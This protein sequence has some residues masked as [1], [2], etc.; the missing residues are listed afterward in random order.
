MTPFTAPWRSRLRPAACLLLFMA[1]GLDACTA[2]RARQFHHH[3]TSGDDH[4]LAR[5]TVACDEASTDCSEL[6]LIKGGACLRLARTGAAPA[7]H[8][9]CSADAL[10]R[11]IALRPSWPEPAARR[12]VQEQLCESLDHLLRWPS[13]ATQAEVG[14]RFRD[15]AQQLYQLAP[16]SVAAT[17][18]LAAARMREIEPLL[19]D[20]TEPDRIPVCH[21]L[22]RALS[23]VL[24]TMQSNGDATSPEWDRYADAYQRL[25]FELGRAIRTAQCR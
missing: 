3:A 20:I 19:P 17:Y 15:A 7:A 22:K 12:A 16:G 14:A 4:W 10:T 8:Y 25:A 21:R 2:M 23:A 11:G 18:Y 9:A 13:P 1:L 24:T 6:H 5:Q